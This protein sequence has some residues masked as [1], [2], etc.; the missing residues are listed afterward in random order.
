MLTT[1]KLRIPPFILLISLVLGFGVGC[2]VD[3]DY[4][5]DPLSFRASLED[6]SPLDDGEM[7]VALRVCYAYRSKRAKFFNELINS[8]FNFNYSQTNCTG[9]VTSTR[10]DTT[11]RQVVTDGPMS[12]EAPAFTFSYAREVQTDLYG[13]LAS[14]CNQVLKGETPLDFIQV[15]NVY[16]EYIFESGLY[17]TV[18]IKKAMQ[19]TSEGGV[20]VVS[21]HSFDI[22]TNQSSAGDYLGLVVKNTQVF[23]CE[24][25]P[26][27][28]T[29]TQEFIEP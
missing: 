4:S 23:P 26:N 20:E 19:R 25:S 9:A 24:G 29:I 17:D 7:G 21:S 28:K 27:V 16:T 10:L 14:I 15:E 18:T 6:G 1:K 8:P 3:K 5:G 12:F 2:G 22:L 11:L 13:E